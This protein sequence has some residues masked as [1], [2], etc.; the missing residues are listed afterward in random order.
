MLAIVFPSI[1]PVLMKIGNIEIFWYGICY[2]LGILISL[3]VAKKLDQ[4]KNLKL[5][6]NKSYD[7]FLTYI[8]FGIIVGGRLGYVIFYH[9]SWLLEEPLRVFKTW[10][11]GM[12]FHGGVIG[13]VLANYLFCK[14][15]SIS[16]FN[17]MDIVACVA[18]IGIFFGRIGNFI[19]AELYGKITNVP[20]GFIFPNT[21]LLPRH[22][23]QLYEGFTEGLLVFFIMLYLVLRTD[24][25]DKKGKLSGIFLVSYS[26]FR[27]INEFFRQ[28]DWHI[29]Y[30]LF[31]FV[32]MGQLLSLPFFFLGVFLLFRRKMV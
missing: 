15:N 32:T 4:A 25:I 28:P 23:S 22:P 9:I 18:P 27:L 31:D 13:L 14:K 2:L 12:S 11:G 29:G 5:L 19:N 1:D 17:M 8:I 20:W 3:L 16:F 24:M 26:F 7:T 6:D 21:D 10:E 30:V